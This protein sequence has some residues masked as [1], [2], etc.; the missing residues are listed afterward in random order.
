MTSKLVLFVSKEANAS[1]TRYRALQFFPYLHPHGFKAI[2]VTVS[3]GIL[4][5]IKTLWKASQADTVVVIRKTFPL[6]LTWMLRFVSKRLIF[7]LDDAIFCHSDGS[8][9]RTRMKRFA[10]MAKSSDHIFAG[11]QFLAE[12]SMMFN[13]AVTIIP[14]CLDVSKYDVIDNRSEDFI[15]LVWIG[16]KSTSKYLIDV[17]PSLEKVAERQPKLRLKIIADFNL[18]DTTMP[19][20]SI[21]WDEK[22]E[23]KELCSSHI[24][25]A[26][27]R[28]NDWTR[29]K[30]ALKVLQYMAAGLPVVSSDVGVNGEAVIDDVTGY[31]VTTDEQWITAIENLLDNEA[32]RVSMGEAGHNRVKQYYDIGIVFQRMLAV[33]KQ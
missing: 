10:A 17:L 24:G 31:L 16:S 13:D 6:V 8:A 18:P 7:D 1:S 32:Q 2:H 3:G 19:V 28:D 4:A 22:T 26:P 27:M 25:I 15:D 12:K 14:T 11:N 30:C 20:L 21:I 33:L 5:V 29:G 9:S 23:A